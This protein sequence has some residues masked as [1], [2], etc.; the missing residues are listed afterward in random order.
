MVEN[1]PR[2]RAPILWIS[3]LG[4]GYLLVDVWSRF[5]RPDTEPRV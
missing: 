2:F 4:T 3:L 1:D 5:R